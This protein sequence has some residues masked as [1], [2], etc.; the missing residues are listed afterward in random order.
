M[1]MLCSLPAF[2]HAGNVAALQHADGGMCWLQET[3]AALEDKTAELNRIRGEAG[4]SSQQI[5]A[6]QVTLYIHHLLASLLRS[7][8]LIKLD[9][10]VHFEGLLVNN[11]CPT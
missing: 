11:A 8:G 4:G 3:Q 7:V 1:L 9:A 5:A 2:L 6:L 10:N